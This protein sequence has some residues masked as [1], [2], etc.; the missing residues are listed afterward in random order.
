[1]CLNC[2]SNHVHCEY[3]QHDRKRTPASSDYAQ[4]LERRVRSLEAR[5]AELEG[6]NGHAADDVPQPV[7]QNLTSQTYLT[8]NSGRECLTLDPRGSLIYHGTTSI[9]RDT[10]NP[11]HFLQATGTTT[12]DYEH[13][14]SHFGIDL[15]GSAIMTGLQ[16]FFKWQYLNFMFIYREAFLE[17]YF[18]T[19]AA[20]RYWSPALLL[21]VCA[22]GLLMSDQEN[23]KAESS[24]YFNAAESIA[25]VTGLADPSVVAVQTFLCLAFYS[26]CN[27][28][29][30]KIG[31]SQVILTSQGVAF[32]MAQD[33]SFQKD[34]E[35]WLCDDLSIL[36]DVDIE[37]RRRIYWGC[38]SSD[39][40]ISLI[41]G[42]PMH[43]AYDAAEVAMLEM[44]P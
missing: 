26:I 35:R 15:E 10:G 7:A 23:H 3:R 1:P 14:A 39:K 27:G 17:D 41:L 22:L 30:Q 32:R 21:S 38:H 2:A 34:P 9:L 37:V 18:G 43:L 29:C 5:I 20:R 16:H 8:S 13:V 11:N 19:S 24:K 33:L 40:L 4:S 44:I 25:L 6:L 36:T 28:I 31:H 42:R 12:P